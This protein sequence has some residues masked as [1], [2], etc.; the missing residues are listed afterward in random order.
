[1]SIASVL[2]RTGLRYNTCSIGYRTP[3]YVLYW[4]NRLKMNWAIY[5]KM[6]QNSHWL[7]IASS[8]S[9]HSY[10]SPI[11]LYSLSVTVVLHCNVL[12]V[13]LLYRLLALNVVPNLCEPFFQC[14]IICSSVGYCIVF[15]MLLFSLSLLI[16]KCCVALKT[17][18]SVA[19]QLI[20][21]ILLLSFMQRS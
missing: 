4:V 21:V 18:P 14:V 2:W 15:S 6:Q 13:Q 16:I 11:S 8:H 10:L 3:Y 20:K 17:P 19:L 9:S 5:A 1:M 7:C 12:T